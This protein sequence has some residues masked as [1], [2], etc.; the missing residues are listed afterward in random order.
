MSFSRFLR[1]DAADQLFA[2]QRVSV[3]FLVFPGSAPEAP[4][5][6]TTIRAAV[7]KP[8]ADIADLTRREIA[9]LQAKHDPAAGPLIADRRKQL[10]QTTPDCASR[11]QSGGRCSC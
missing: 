11:G 10:Q 5:V 7:T 6:V 1:P 4:R 3:V 8:A 9:A 2:S